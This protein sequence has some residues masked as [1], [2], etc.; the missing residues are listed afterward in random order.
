M[1]PEILADHE[2]ELT[3]MAGETIGD[4]HDL[5]RDLDRRIGLFDRKIDRVFRESETCQRI[6]Q[7]KGVGPKTATAIV[8]AISGIGKDACYPGANAA[9]DLG[10]RWSRVYGRHK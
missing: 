2:N 7:I 5:F 4:L 6:E 3:P 10:G 1:I 8:A 9:L